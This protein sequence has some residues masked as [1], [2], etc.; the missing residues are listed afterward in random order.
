MKINNVQKILEPGAGH[1]RDTILFA[2]GGID[3]EV[4]D[5]SSEGIKILE[6]V[7]KEKGL[8]IRSRVFDIKTPFPFPNECFDAVYLHMLFNVKFSKGE[9][10]LIFSEIRRVLKPNGLIFFSKKT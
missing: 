3:I 6:K 4:L 9:L 5:Y 2:T 1:G 8:S 7:A 10:H